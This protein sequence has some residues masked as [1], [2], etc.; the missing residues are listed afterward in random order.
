MLKVEE[1]YEKEIKTFKERHDGSEYVS[2]EKVYDTRDC[3]LNRE[4]IV[5]IQPYYFTTSSDDKKLNGRFP[6]GT[7]F[8]VF[9]LD[10]NSFRSSEIIVVG[11]FEKFCRMLQEHDS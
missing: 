9:V 8:C 7:K 3:L 5:S 2:F 1:V 11:S 10:G 6:E 4:Y